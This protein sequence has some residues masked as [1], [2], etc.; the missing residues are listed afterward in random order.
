M[1]RIYEPHGARGQTTLT[2][3]R[4]VKSVKRVNLLE[5]VQEGAAPTVKEGSTISLDLRPFEVVSLQLGF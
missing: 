5:D 3:D 4:R 1:L 2:F